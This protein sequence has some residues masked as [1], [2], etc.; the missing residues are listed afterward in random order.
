METSRLTQNLG[1][2]LP[3]G[4]QGHDPS[5]MGQTHERLAEL[6]IR[7]GTVGSSCFTAAIRNTVPLRCFLLASVLPSA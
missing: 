2:S 7:L 3:V 5:L 6:N 4:L 1:P